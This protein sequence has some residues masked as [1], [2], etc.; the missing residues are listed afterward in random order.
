MSKLPVVVVGDGASG[1]LA[2]TGLVRRGVGPVLMIGSGR[3]PGTGLAYRTIEPVHLLNSRADC[4][5][6]RT[7][8]P[9]DFVSWCRTTG[10]AVRGSDFVAR[11]RYGAYLAERLGQLGDRGEVSARS[12]RVVRVQPDGD[13]AVVSLADGST[14]RARAVVLAT[15]HD[16]PATPPVPGLAGAPW[17]A[18]DPWRTGVLDA[19]TRAGSVLLL[20]TGLTAVDIALAVH[21][22][23]P[24]ATVHAVSRHG[25]VPANH[26]PDPPAESAM[27][28]RLAVTTTRHLLGHVRH[29]V[30]AG[31]DWRALVDELRVQA[32]DIWGRLPHS[33]RQ[34]FLRH[35]NRYWQVHRHRMAPPVAQAIGHL[36]ETGALRVTAGRPERIE[37]ERSGA[38][39]TVRVGDRQQVLHARMVVNCTGPG[40]WVA[41]PDPLA[42]SLRA[43]G[44]VR[45]DRLGLGLACD[46]Y[47]RLLDRTGRP[48]DWLWALGPLRLG[49]S[50]ETTAVPEIRGQADI[51]ARA[52]AGEVGDA[53]DWTA[54]A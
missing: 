1:V 32:D 44:L 9:N 31:A 13:E 22:H 15:G 53:L 38:A 5:S 30:A 36:R 18:A 6:V 40:R 20:G 26:L 51:I 48:T 49:T 37:A 47:G 12:G 3:T 27:S 39:M 11:R 54:T 19:A 42:V 24:D 33:E 50:I 35:V 10:T 4:M 2:V 45:L 46:E 41:G 28:A 17:Y 16:A 52:L 21:R 14:V 8:R 23:R 29:A 25:L 43:A 34:R 7:D